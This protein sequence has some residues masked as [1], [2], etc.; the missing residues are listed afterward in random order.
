MIVDFLKGACPPAQNVVQAASNGALLI[1]TS[2]LAEV[3]VAML[4]TRED[5]L[6]VIDEFF[7]QPYVFVVPFSRPIRSTARDL[8]RKF[9]LRAADAIYVASAI[10]KG[11]PTFETMD[12]QVLSKLSSLP[13]LT[14]TK[15]FPPG[16]PQQ[17]KMN[18]P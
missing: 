8:V 6:G 14:V 13:G 2:A 15:P 17:L 11:V 18:L 12:G 1:A 5:D 3:E 7:A 4:P 16:P 9:H 10:N